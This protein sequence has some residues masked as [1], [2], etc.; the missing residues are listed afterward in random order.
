M[1]DPETSTKPQ[2]GHTKPIAVAVIVVIA[3]IGIVLLTFAHK[4]SVTA[5]TSTVPVTTA[6]S[7]SVPTS[8]TIKDEINAACPCLNEMQIE[9]ILGGPSSPAANFSVGYLPDAAAVH[10][11]ASI[12][13]FGKTN[14]STPTNMTAAW[15]ISYKSAQNGPTLVEYIIANSDP[16]WLSNYYQTT[17]PAAFK[18]S[19]GSVNGFQYAYNS[20]TQGGE[21][22]LTLIGNKDG[23]TVVLMVSGQAASSQSRA[24][25]NLSYTI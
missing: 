13:S 7:T 18:F 14:S 22:K 25:E 2:A 6:A 23:Y 4:A 24:A 20:S 5:T 17:G 12:Q 10:A 9:G 1:A 19:P 16:Q 11:N 3:L 15:V 8:S 21:Q